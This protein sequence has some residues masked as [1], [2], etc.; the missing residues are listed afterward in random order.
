VDLDVIAVTSFASGP[1]GL[2]T[3]L[4]ARWSGVKAVVHETTP[5]CADFPPFVHIQSPPTTPVGESLARLAG[6]RIDHHVLTAVAGQYQPAGNQL[7]SDDDVAVRRAPR[8]F[9]I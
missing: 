7:G 8:D 2:R 4:G 9:T 1:S 3:T 5:G 6:A